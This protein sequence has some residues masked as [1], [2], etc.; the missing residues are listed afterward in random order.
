MCPVC[1]LFVRISANQRGLGNAGNQNSISSRGPQHLNASSG[2]RIFKDDKSHHPAFND[3]PNLPDCQLG[4]SA[5]DLG[6]SISRLVKPLPNWN[7]ENVKKPEAR[8]G[9]DLDVVVLF[10]GFFFR[11][12][13]IWLCGLSVV[14]LHRECKGFMVLA[15]FRISLS[16]RVARASCATH[17]YRRHAFSS[18]LARHL[19]PV[20]VRVNYPGYIPRVE[21]SAAQLPADQ[22]Q[23]SS[24]DPVGILLL[25]NRHYSNRGFPR[26]R[27]TL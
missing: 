21:P 2:L 18:R 1:H 19:V 4:A 16:S 12:L 8:V 22:W 13:A 26:F 23:R 7:A 20:V 25:S 11:F 10:L 3:L 15:C 17:L 27:R 5:A 6:E 24:V 9:F 14:Q